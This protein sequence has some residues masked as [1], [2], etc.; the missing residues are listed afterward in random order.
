MECYSALNSAVIQIVET[1]KL[2]VCGRSFLQI[3]S[4]NYVYVCMCI[5]LA[6]HIYGVALLSAVDNGIICENCCDIVLS[7]Y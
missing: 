5:T 1:C 7:L 2:D 6:M 4:H 3:Q